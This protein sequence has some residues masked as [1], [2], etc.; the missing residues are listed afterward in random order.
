MPDTTFQPDVTSTKVC[1]CC[2]EPKPLSE[3]YL[4]GTSYQRRCKQ[5]VAL[6][7]RA[8]LLYREHQDDPYREWPS[9]LQEAARS[10]ATFLKR[11]GK[12]NY[13]HS[14]G[15][16][17]AAA[18]LA[19]YP[20][21]LAQDSDLVDVDKVITDTLRQLVDTGSVD[22]NDEQI[23]GCAAA[24]KTILQDTAV[25]LN[26]VSLQ[27]SEVYNV[28]NAY[29]SVNT[30]FRNVMS[31]NSPLTVQC[32]GPIAPTQGDSNPG[33]NPSGQDIQERRGLL[34]K[35]S[36]NDTLKEAF[37]AEELQDLIQTLDS[38]LRQQ[39]VDGYLNPYDLRKIVLVFEEYQ[40]KMPDELLILYRKYLMPGIK[41]AQVREDYKTLAQIVEN[42]AGINFYEEPWE[43]IPHIE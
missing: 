1:S 20:E 42:I 31:R 33:L 11:G 8:A 23:Q 14:V 34:A 40:Q 2:K 6:D 28:L 24:L 26:K 39:V 35:I 30:Q 38:A 7:R 9:E 36:N 10:F 18:F 12:I 37:G 27:L 17:L 21:E 19:E 22:L 13:A 43:S 16:V 29:A 32:A 15:Q 4:S 25:T 5:C 3:Y 41:A